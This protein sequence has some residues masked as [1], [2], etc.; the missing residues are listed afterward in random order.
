VTDISRL[1]IG[2]ARAAY[3]G[4]P[5][6]L[7]PH[8]NAACTVAVALE[9]PIDLRNWHRKSGWGCWQST[10]V[11]LIP[12]DTLHHMKCKGRMLFLYLDPRSD[13]ASSINRQALENFRDALLKQPEE[14]WTLGK[15]TELLGVKQ[16]RQQTMPLRETPASSLKN[17]HA[18]SRMQHALKIIDNSPATFKTIEQA[19]AVACLSPSRFRSLFIRHTGLTFRRYRL[20]RRMAAVVLAVSQGQNLTEAALEAGFSDSA[21][22]S[23]A[24]RDMFGISPSQLF[25]RGVCVQVENLLS[26]STGQSPGQSPSQS[27]SHLARHSPA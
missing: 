13:E 12:G 6:D 11:A 15:M 2:T 10:L 20:W 14:Y 21:H 4:P 19:A 17:T 27:S 18:F 25:G 16:A 23:A 3:I 5:F 1:L 22:L 8:V 7:S 9:H 24:F 26:Q